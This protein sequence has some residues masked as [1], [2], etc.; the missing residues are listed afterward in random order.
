MADLFTYLAWRGDLSFVQAGFNPVDNLIM[1]CLAYVQLEKALPAGRKK[2]LAQAAADYLALPEEER[3]A[4]S[5][6][7]ERLLKA[8]ADSHRFGRVELLGAVDILD[9]AAEKQFA[10]VTFQLENGE[11]YVAYRGTDNS[12]TGWKEDFN[13]AYLPVVPSQTEAAAY[14][15]R[16]AA[17]VPGGIRVGGHS[18]GGNLAVF[19]AAVSQPS[20]Q[21]RLLAVYNN[22]GPGFSSRMLQSP[23]Y[24]AVASCIHT[25]IPQSSVVGMLLDHEE[26]YAVVHSRRVGLLQHDPYSWDVMGPDFVYVSGLTP[27]GQMIDRTLKYWVAQM[28]ME[29]RADFVEGLFS[30]LAAREKGQELLPDDWKGNLK[31]VLKGWRKL[32]ADTRKSL[33]GPLSRLIRTAARV[34]Q[35]GL[36]DKGRSE[37]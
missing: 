31:A 35:A 9:P 6:E 24:R 26:S 19:A 20:L 18:K 4:R 16:A 29:E 14:L 11:A 21:R 23:G 25:Y 15:E 12:L 1:S 13:M 3:R 5:G 2:T 27:A 32:P 28:S 7:D 37:A 22:D 34:M 17:A 30:L 33:K 8:A 36:E 10:A